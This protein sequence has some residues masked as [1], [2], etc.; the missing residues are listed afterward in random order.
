MNESKNEL[1]PNLVRGHRRDGRCQYDKTA[2]REL[3]RRCLE[4][5]VSLAATSLA[6]GLNANLLRKWV[7]V[8]GGRVRT[9]QRVRALA[10][11]QPPLLPVKMASRAATGAPTEGYVEISVRGGVIRVYGRVPVDSLR[12]VL[13]CLASRA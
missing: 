10:A 8:L 11:A 4:P 7:D 1:V 12:A 5:G 2:K 3:V 9:V 13:D 6:H